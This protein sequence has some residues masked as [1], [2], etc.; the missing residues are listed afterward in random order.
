MTVARMRSERAELAITV[1]VYGAPWL[2]Y[3]S[4]LSAGI[5]SVNT[6][7]VPGTLV[8]VIVPP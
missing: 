8:A 1:G 4:A 3:E 2:A 7:S 5:F 6:V